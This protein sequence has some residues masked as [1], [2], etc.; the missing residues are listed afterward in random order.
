LL[1]DRQTDKQTRAKTFTSSFVWDN[2]RTI[3]YDMEVFNVQSKNWRSDS[4]LSLS[5]EIRN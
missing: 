1:T 5:H 3:R 4:Q 2:N